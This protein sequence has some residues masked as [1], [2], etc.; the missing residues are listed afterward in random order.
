MI[1][2]ADAR[3]VQGGFD[4]SHNG[5]RCDEDKTTTSPG[6]QSLCGQPIPH[7]QAADEEVCI[8]DHA[9]HDVGLAFSAH[10]INSLGHIG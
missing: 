8:E 10:G 1:F 7:E 5:R 6:L 2:A 9:K 3:V 4:L